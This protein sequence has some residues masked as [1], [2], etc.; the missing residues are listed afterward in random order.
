MYSVNKPTKPE[1]PLERK[2]D[3]GW[4]AWF[5]MTLTNR[6]TLFHLATLA[7][8]QVAFAASSYGLTRAML[9]R[10]LNERSG[11]TLDT[12]VAA[13]EVEPDGLDWEPESRKLQLSG[14][15]QPVWAIF[16]G[17]GRRIDGSID[18]AQSLESYATPGSDMEQA[19][20]EVV[21]D[22][23]PWWILRRTVHHPHPEAVLDGRQQAKPRHRTLVFLTAWP[24]AP[25]FETLQTLLWCI[26]GL[27]TAVWLAAAFA[28]RWLCR[29]ALAPV[30]RMAESV[31]AITVD[32]LGERLAVPKTHDELHELATSFNG[33]LNRLQ[34]SFARQ[35]R[36]TGEA[37]HQLRTP[38]SAMLGQIEVALR[39]ERPPE[40]YRR[41]LGAAHAQ[42][43]RLS[44][45][46][47]TLLFLAR[48]DAEASLPSPN[49][50]IFSIGS[51]DTWKA[52][53]IIR[54][55]PTCCWTRH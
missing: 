40:E 48:A 25:V 43:E 23:Q 20:V 26:V 7:V 41:A 52:G 4:F 46:V 19:R 37:S 30:T 8:V 45:I 38:L 44:R 51:I 1:Q 27:S 53:T 54:G 39:R 29:R 49:D 16:D 47:E 28:G 11:N 33:L 13:A 3:A 42:A 22:K 31:G 24:L 32:D 15:A 55:K 9:L 18:Q 17:N 2:L 5:I 12:L 14:G 36:F 10:Q 21:W 34:E 6:L 35:S 50:S